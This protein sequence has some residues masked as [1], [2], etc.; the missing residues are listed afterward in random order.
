MCASLRARLIELAERPDAE[1]VLARARE[2]K[3]RSGAVLVRERLLEHRDA[4]RH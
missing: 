1:A 3:A 2:R 4:D